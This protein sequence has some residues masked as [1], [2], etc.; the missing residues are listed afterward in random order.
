MR[1]GR[2]GVSGWRL[3]WILKIRG[4]RRMNARGRI[5]GIAGDV[6]VGVGTAIG[7]VVLFVL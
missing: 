4:D 1:D 3:S 5:C 7:C 6:G 2:L